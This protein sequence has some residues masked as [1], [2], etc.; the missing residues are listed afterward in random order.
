V[1]LRL[2]IAGVAGLA[3]ALAVLAAA[4]GLY[5]A[6]RSDLRGQIDESLKQR[7]HVFVGG[8]LLRAGA[9]GAVLLDGRAPPQG[10]DARRAG[11]AL[12]P[13]HV[14]PAR[15]GGASGYVQFI[16]R[17]GTIVVPGGQGSTPKIAPKLYRLDIRKK[18]NEL[19]IRWMS[20]ASTRRR[21]A[22]LA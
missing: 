18:Q 8:P 4:I 22:P 21:K 14:Q 10:S 17:N 15:F 12:L 11:H 9:P 13:R 3:V 19:I 16:S 6:V 5:L 7:T 1:S 20:M 2:R